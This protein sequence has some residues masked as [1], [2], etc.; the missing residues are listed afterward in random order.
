MSFCR[1]PPVTAAQH[2]HVRKTFWLTGYLESLAE[3]EREGEGSVRRREEKN[4][5]CDNSTRKICWLCVSVFPSSLLCSRIILQQCLDYESKGLQCSV[6]TVNRM[7][8]Y[9]TNTTVSV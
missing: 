3:R 7:V 6:D 2:W 5:E 4:R 1:S 8:M 9:S